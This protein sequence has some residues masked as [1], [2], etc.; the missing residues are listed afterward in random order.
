MKLIGITSAIS[1]SKTCL[2]SAYVNAFTRP[3]IAP[4]ILPEFMP[5]NRELMDLA[6]YTAQYKDKIDTYVER[7]DALVLSGGADIHP[8][9]YDEVNDGASGCDQMR[10][11]MELSLLDGFVRA[12]KPVLGICRGLQLIG[13]YLGLPN[14]QQDTTSEQHVAT[15]FDYTRRQEVCHDIFLR[16]D[17]KT[18]LEGKKGR[19]LKSVGINSFHHQSFTLSDDGKF[20]KDKKFWTWHYQAIEKIESEK[21]ID[22]LATTHLVI[23]AFKHKTA[24]ILALQF[25]NEEYQ[26]N[27]LFTQYWLDK[28]VLNT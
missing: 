27:G 4:I 26:E 24:P 18:Y 21:K 28:F 6:D 12:N 16:G 14:F 9:S 11:F 10:D 23:E 7:L 20:P 13:N 2:N 19:E 8:S 1:E 3:N 25:H 5:K 15:S 17:L 22:I